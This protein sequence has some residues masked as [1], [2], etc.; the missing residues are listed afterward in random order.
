MNT[1]KKIFLTNKIKFTINSDN[2]K[3][4]W[5]RYRNKSWKKPGKHPKVRE[6]M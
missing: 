6:K 4:K 2:R 3:D 5:E 1:G